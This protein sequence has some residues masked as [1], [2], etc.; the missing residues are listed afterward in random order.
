MKRFLIIAITA[1]SLA[2]CATKFGEVISAAQNFTVT[3]GQVDTAR[4]SYNG[5]VLAPLY[6]Y[7]KLP[8]CLTG[9]KFTLNV[10]CHDRSLLKQIRQVDKTVEKA[11]NDTQ[12]AIDNGNNTGAVAAY[13][14]L[15]NTIDIAKALIN[16]TG[17]SLIGG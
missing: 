15:T 1:L 17:I 6:K 9:Q 12:E 7:A 16:Q 11:F 4:N 5:F 3:Q 8:R 2:G 10:P 13:T 14:T